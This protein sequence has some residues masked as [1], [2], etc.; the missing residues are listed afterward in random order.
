MSDIVGRI[1]VEL[2][3]CCCGGVWKSSVGQMS[4]VESQ[5]PDDEEQRVRR[6]FLI[7][8]KGLVVYSLFDSKNS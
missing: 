5:R 2:G 8:G 1:S 4:F 3:R 7:I 6:C